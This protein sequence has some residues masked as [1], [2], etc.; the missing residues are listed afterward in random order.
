MF[1]SSFFKPSSL[2]QKVIGGI[3]EKKGLVHLNSWNRM[4]C[5]ANRHV[6]ELNIDMD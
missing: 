2:R 3:C 1:A 6:L 5:V 4:V